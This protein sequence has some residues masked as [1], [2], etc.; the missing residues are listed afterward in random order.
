[1]SCMRGTRKG[2][3]DSVDKSEL[4]KLMSDLWLMSDFLKRSCAAAWVITTVRPF[5]TIL[6]FVL[7]VES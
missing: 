2:T 4:V 3:T 7:F 1:M 5:V 6:I